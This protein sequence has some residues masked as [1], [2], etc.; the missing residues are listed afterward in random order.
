M[1]KYTEFFGETTSFE[2]DTAI[3]KLNSEAILN[4][5]QWEQQIDAW[6]APILSNPKLPEFL[7]AHLF[8]ELYYTSDS[9]CYW[10]IAKKNGPANEKT[11]IDLNDQLSIEQKNGNDGKH[12][13]YQEGH[14]YRLFFIFF[15]LI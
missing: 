10:T 11:N 3:S 15:C 1:K 7:K 5:N 12:F 2:D 4:Y 9:G 14:A 6:Q 8:N 13:G